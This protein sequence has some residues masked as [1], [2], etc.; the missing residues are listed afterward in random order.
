MYEADVF[1]FVPVKDSRKHF[2]E[3]RISMCD[4]PRSRR[5]LTDDVTDAIGSML[6]ERPFISCKVLC[7]HF[8]IAKTRWLRVPRERF[9]MKKSN[10]CWI[11]SVLAMNRN[12]EGPTVSHGL[13]VVFQGDYLTNFQNGIILD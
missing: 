6:K 8:H 11:S 1:A 5:P 10:H 7:R 13:S 9:G 4:E 3:G 12:A 2:T